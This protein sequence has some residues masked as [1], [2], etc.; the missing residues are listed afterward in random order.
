MILDVTAKTKVADLTIDFI[1]VITRLGK[2]ISIDWDTSFVTRTGDIFEARYVGVYFNEEYANGKLEDLENMT[3]DVVELY[4]EEDSTMD[5]E[6]VEMIFYD[7]GRELTFKDVYKTEDNTMYM[8]F[9]ER[10]ETYIEAQVG[11]GFNEE[12]SAF[13]ENE[14]DSGLFD[15]AY[16]LKE[17]IQEN[18]FNP[19]TEKERLSDDYGKAFDDWYDSFIETDILP[20]LKRI[21]YERMEERK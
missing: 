20:N 8:N 15:I 12:L 5:I 9:R 11:R 6:I 14:D 19:F 16:N 2:S 1:Q 17:T 10:L 21:A 18:E 4:S 3:V 7:E 13:T